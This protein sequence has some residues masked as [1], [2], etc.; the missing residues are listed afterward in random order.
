MALTANRNV[1]HYIDQQLRTFAVAGSTHVYKGA[2]VGLKADGYVRGL[3]A[4]DPFIGIAYEEIDN[5]SGSDGDKS[6]RVYT[7]G[8][9]GHA[10]SG[11]AITDIG[12]P[13]FASADDTLTFAGEGNSYVGIVE[14]FL[15]TS[16]IMLR[17]DAG[18]GRIRTIV[19]AVED[20][21]ANADIAARAIHAFEAAA[22][23]VAAR[24]VNQASAAAGIDDS[25]TCV[26][27][28]TLGGSALVSETFDS[29]TAFPDANEAHGMGALSNA[30]ASAGE[31]LT[32]AVTNGTTANPGPFLVEVDYV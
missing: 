12:R 19:H 29:T 32:L 28:L 2:L 11:A 7:Q 4:G 3:V 17:L 18:G 15:A 14:D 5:S 25:N 6:V 31:V 21:A 22:W 24:V 13:L 8:D 16:E 9:F 10:L 30:F 27:A 23:V 20:L 26:V 1:D